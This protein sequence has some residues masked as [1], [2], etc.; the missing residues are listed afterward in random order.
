MSNLIRFGLLSL[1]LETGDL[2]GS[3]RGVRLP[4]QQFMILQLLLAHD[5]GVVSR[6][7]IQSRLWPGDTIVEF[8]RSIN[9]AILKLRSAL[10]HTSNNG[11]YIDTVARRGYRLM[12]SVKHEID[13]SKT[14]S[15]PP[16]RNAPL[17]GQNISHYRVLSVLGGGRTGVVYKGEDLKLNRPVALKFLTKNL[18]QTPSVLKQ[19]EH[20]ARTASSLNHLNICTIYQIGEYERQ[21][22]IV[23][24]F[25]EGEVLR[26]F[27]AGSAGLNS[28]ERAALVPKLLG[29]AIQIAD[30]LAAAHARGVI[31][32]DIKPANVIVTKSG[33]AKLLDFGLARQCVN[34]QPDSK[35]SLSA[36][37]SRREP[38]FDSGIPDYMSPEQIKGEPQDQRSDLFSF[39]IL[40]AELF[41]SAHPFRRGALAETREAILHDS[42]NLSSDLP[43]ALLLLIRRLLAR[44]LDLRYSSVVEVKADLERVAG[45]LSAAQQIPDVSR[46]PLIGRDHELTELR[47]KLY[48]ALAGHGSMVLIGGE[49]GVGKSHLAR[50]VLEEAQSRGALGIVGH[51]YE[52]E[53]APPYVPFIE[54][55][56][57]ITRMA[58]REGL[59]HS[60]GDHA[61]EVARLM[62]ELRN[63]YPD[64]PAAITLPPEQRRRYLF[65]AFRSFVE[66]A[67]CVTPLVFLFEDLQWAD[68]PTLLLL[69]HHAQTLSTTPI[70]VI[71]TYRD[72]ELEVT[73]PFAQTLESLVRE[74]QAVRL[75]LRRL[76]Q[77]G[78]HSM[79]AAISGHAPP[80]SVVRAFFGQTEGNPFFV[81]E[82]F[83]HLSEEG[84][85]FDKDGEWL[86]NLPADQLQ[87]PHGVRL[88]LGRRLNRLGEDARRVL[89]TAAIIGRSFSM[90]LLEALENRQPDAA[91]DAVE[92]AERAH[93]LAPEPG[94]RDARYQFVH[95]LICQTLSESLSLPRR[96]RLHLSIAEGIQKVYARHLEA[97]ASQLAHHLYQAGAA[98]DPETTTKYLLIA[99][100]QARAGAAHEE[101][102]EHLDRAL[103]LWE[104]NN[105]PHAAELFEQKASVLRSIGRTDEAITSYR[106]AIQLFE[107]AQ[108]LER[109]ADASIALSYLQAWG[110]NFEAA[111]RT[112]AHAHNLMQGQNLHSLSS[113]LSMRAAIMSASGQPQDAEQMFDEARRLSEAMKAPSRG[114]AEMLEAIHYYQSFQLTKVRSTSPQVAGACRAAGDAWD[115]SSV[116]FYG[117][118][119]DLYSGKPET[120]AAAL[121]NAALR[122]EKIGHHGAVWALKLGESVVSASRGNLNACRDETVEAWEFGAAHGVG[123]NFAT[124]IQRGHL[125]LWSGDMEQAEHWY[126]H[127]LKF[128]GK[129]YLGG[130][131]EACLF[132]ACAECGAPRAVEIWTNRRWQ[133]PVPGQLNSLGAW[134][135]LERSVVG[136]AHMGRSEDIAALRP[137]T[138]ELILTGAWTYS[139]LS[140]FRTVAGIAAACAGDWPAAEQHHLAAISQT[141]SAPYR[142]L[143]PVAREW[144][145]AMLLARNK[146]DEAARAHALL[147]EAMTLYEVMGWQQRARHTRRM[148]GMP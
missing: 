36:E 75:P 82:L 143:Q 72:M 37:E 101:A 48:E 132:A 131:S 41:G 34:S 109:V 65:N 16:A 60:L 49:A 6:E 98:A 145:A 28:K 134:T 100:R 86:T 40:L 88:V 111:N 73:R 63:M 103:S 66:R 108:D 29:I 124:S 77:G 114:R 12:V 91:L 137:L 87:V 90:D 7:E 20:E 105:G 99:A 3:K 9:A 93:L 135:A 15:A 62:P 64:I 112:M 97:Q 139:L 113:V 43:P 35:I 122:A 19:L 54:M 140:P 104:D 30:G 129:S 84:K 102:L 119:A 74:K 83:R 71:G 92:E 144:Y 115:A 33:T 8:D 17:V 68:E 56:E 57:Y 24:E 4:E 121:A 53:G 106:K 70:L 18:A 125:A 128:E 44:S 78:V 42:P 1:N 11:V 58:P 79:L 46:M 55:L 141:D 38:T 127:G 89:T 148:L 13:E 116:E 123:W 138:E 76:P 25:L 81:E 50:A 21:P 95:E 22:F 94:S 126:T 26:E 39:G 118:W 147:R 14:D 51:C 136:L 23:M 52:R 130:L 69:Q 61:P 80:S 142:H 2:Q 146:A 133:L 31:H 10:R 110:L 107:A 47:R 59:R 5:G 117:L 85:L 67:A 27:I 96:Q 45:A 120:C 32:R